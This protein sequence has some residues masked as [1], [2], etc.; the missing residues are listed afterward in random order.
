MTVTEWARKEVELA[1]KKENPNWDGKSFDYGCSCYGSALKAFETL[2]NDGHSG[3]SFNATKNILKRLLDCNPLTPIT[4]DD[5]PGR[6]KDNSKNTY[7]AD[8]GLK[9]SIQCP[10]KSSLFREEDLNGNVTYHEVDRSYCKNIEF[11][12]DTFTSSMDRIV[13]EIAPITMP[14]YGESGKWIV[15]VSTFLCDKTHGDYDRHSV[16][17]VESP[18]G[19]IYDIQRYWREDKSGKMV[20]CTKEEYEYDKL[21]LR[22][23][24]ITKNIAGR[25]GHIIHYYI[26]DNNLTVLTKEENKEMYDI[27]DIECAMFED[28]EP[29]YRTFDNLRKIVKGEFECNDTNFMG[30]I[31][32]LQEIIAPFINK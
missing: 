7:K 16:E 1:C 4:D 21:N 27:L 20:E 25:L 24:T 11:P 29:K 14:Y 19:K 12:D 8:M 32:H 6:D 9:T 26:E 23:D 30:K 18:D 28:C 31:Q 13:D 10:R 2:M 5:F 22:I 3:Y 17:K 15:Y